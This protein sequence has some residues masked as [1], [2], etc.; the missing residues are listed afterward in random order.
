MET[1]KLFQQ[2][3]RKDANKDKLAASVIRK[4]ELAPE[5]VAAL[6]SDQAAVK[7]S[8][9]K[10]LLLISERAPAV[11]YPS[12]HSFIDLLDCEN[13]ILKWGAVR[14]IG[15]LAEVD[16]KNIIDRVLEK[17]LEPISGPELVTAANVIAGA[18]KIAMAKP[19]LIDRIVRAILNV[20][21]ARYKTSM[22]R[23]VALGRAIDAF[24]Q[25]YGRSKLQGAI[26]KLVK[27]QLRNPRNAT[28]K[29]AEKFIKRRLTSGASKGRAGRDGAGKK[30]M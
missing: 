19:R 17:Y 10:I 28:R 23:N 30:A 22:C 7:F 29:K 12:L 16:S 15:N 13:K 18:T 1:K 4:P 9:S 20:E 24:D 11:V 5:L 26:S 3:A 27:K 25:L 2:L 14:V 6:G 21:K 8:A